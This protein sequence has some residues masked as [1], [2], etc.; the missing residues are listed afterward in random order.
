[1]RKKITYLLCFLVAVG[2]AQNPVVN[3]Q[4]ETSS[5]RIGEQFQFKISVNGTENVI[6]PK[7]VLKGLEIIDSAK[8]DTINNMLIQKYILTGFDSGAFYIPQQQVFVRNQA[9]LTDS[10]LI[11]VATVEIDTTKIKKYPIKSIKSEPYVFDDFKIYIYLLLVALAIIGFWIYYFVIRKR[12]V[13]EEKPLY[14]V[15]PPF[16]EAIYKLNELDNKLLWQNNQVKEY[17]SELTEIVRNYI[18]RELQVPALEKTTD[19]IIEMLRDFHDAKT[20]YTS[21]ETIKKLRELLQEADLVKFAKSK[22]I[23]I[24]IE[25]DRKDA[26]EIISNLK[27]KPIKK[28]ELE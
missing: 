18:E 14:K 9:Y 12:K 10:L 17:Y 16:E 4:V 19:E 6:F 28:D 25:E 5:I 24:E 23:S 11:N 22:P 20:I 26:Q 27:P 13:Q 15:L 7:L 8:V 1:M 21:T 2:F 3:S